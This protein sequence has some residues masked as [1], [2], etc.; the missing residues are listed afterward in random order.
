MGSVNINLA[1]GRSPSIHFL[2][3]KLNKKPFKRLTF[4]IIL[5]KYK[6]IIKSVT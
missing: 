5:L 6:Y 1:R 3:K 4:Y 2:N